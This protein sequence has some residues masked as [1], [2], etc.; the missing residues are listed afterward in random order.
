MQPRNQPVPTNS[1]QFEVH[2]AYS[3]NISGLSGHAALS[4]S[5]KNFQLFSFAHFTVMYL[6]TNSQD[7]LNLAKSNIA[8]ITITH[9]KSYND[10]QQ[11]S[12]IICFQ[13]FL[14]HNIV[15]RHNGYSQIC[16]TFS[17]ALFNKIKI[18]K[19]DLVLS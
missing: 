16:I 19:P 13:M 2:S 8:N 1:Y 14:S 9:Q 6:L 3:T 12:A 15:S 18:Q 10:L 7:K 11:S 5:S 4:R 17:I